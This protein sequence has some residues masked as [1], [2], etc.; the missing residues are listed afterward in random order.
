METRLIIIDGNSLINRAYYAMQRP[1]ITKEGIYTQGIYGFLRMLQKIEK[2]HPAGY[3]AVAFD[4][5]APTFRHKEYDDYKAGRKSMPPE[6]AMQMPL[7]KEV[8]DAMRIKRV[9]LEGYEADDL[10]GTIAKWGETQGLAPLIITGDRDELQLASDLTTVMITRKGISRFDLFDRQAMIDHYGFGPD[11]FIDLKG[12]MGDASDNIP[13][14]PGVGEKTATKLILEF[15]SV[16]SLLQNTDKLKGKLKENVEDNAQLAVM[17]KRL[18][19]IDR[20]APLELNKEDFKW[21]EPDKAALLALYKKLEFTSFIRDLHAD[22][23]DPA[24]GGIALAADGA[25]ADG[26]AP[27]QG[28]APR[29]TPAEALAKI[30]TRRIWRIDDADGIAALGKAFDGSVILKTCGNTG[31]IGTARE[32]GAAL[33]SAA[34]LAG[35]DLYYLALDGEDGPALKET[36]AALIKEKKPAFGGDDLKADY[37]RLMSLGLSEFETAF[38]TS[39]AEYVID[40]SKSDYSIPVLAKEYFAYDLVTDAD[41]QDTQL[42][43]IADP[44]AEA[45]QKEAETAQ[46]AAWCVLCRLV[47]GLQDETIA[48]EGLEKVYRDVELPLIQVMAS[49]EYV[50]FAADA[51]TLRTIGDGI[52]ARV[53]E[54]TAQIYELAGEEFNIKSPAQLGPILFEKLGLPAGKKTKKGYS[55]SADILESLADRHPIIPA[56]LEYRSLTKLTGTYIDGLLPLIRE[57]GRIHAHFNQTI[58]ATGRISSSDPNLQNIPVRQ[59][60]GRTVRKAFVPGGEDRILMGADYSQI[61]LRVL[62]HMS[63]DEALI[64]AF[65]RGEDIHR[66]TAA[67]V[68]GIPEDEITPAERSRAKAVN[69]GVIYGMSAFGLSSNLHITRKEADSYIKDYFAKHGKVKA[70]MDEQ[71]A[72]AKEQGYVT[73]ILGRKRYIKEIN[74]SQYMVRQLGERLAMNSPIQGSAA[75]IIKIAMVNIYRALQP[76][77]SRLILQVHD[78]LIIE[79]YKDEESQIRDL[80]RETMEGAMDLAVKMSVDLNEG[81]NWYVLK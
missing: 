33:T 41:T 4:M 44:D 65:N 18:A 12:L 43:F 69:F 29:Q 38:D 34:F 50:G 78:E 36:L 60:L 11:Q 24:A 58:T 61:E 26:N 15:G 66:A 77:K 48:A 79:T 9:E 31:A 17:S 42:S 62:A 21:E 8:L 52:N 40:P 10:I 28:G 49:M 76:Y 45:K 1:M 46:A 81:E 35:D 32:A 59:E 74:A 63:G 57:D 2:E 3:I 53:D 80:L 56:I 25:Q 55:T 7:L 37:L 51:A 5:K 70:F 22:G 68:L 27:A 73:T 75:D 19:T 71:V 67:H 14:L 47:A 23:A 13:G 64:D 30:K 6:L 16:E 20:D 72:L 54:L 39:I